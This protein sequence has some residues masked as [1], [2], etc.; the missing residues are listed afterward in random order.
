MD[1]VF[2]VSAAVGAAVQLLSVAQEVLGQDLAEGIPEVLDAVS[3]DDG[4]DRRVGVRQD[5][6]EVHDK[7]RLLQLLIKQCEAVE[8]VDGQPANSKQSHYDGEG[9]GDADLLLQQ[10]VVLA[11]PV[12]NSLELDLY[13]LVPGHGEDL[14][15][16]AEHDEQW[17][18]HTEKKVKVDHVMHVHHALKEAQEL[19]A[20][21][22]FSSSPQALHKASVCSVVS[23][24]AAVA[25]RSVL[26]VPAKE[27]DEADDEGEDP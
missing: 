6:G 10:A 13:Q 3:V 21:Y 19:A 12:A 9:F 20:M 14:Q 15:V 18:Q 2:V 25:A 26:Q 4:V 7:I 11:V 16:D 24:S 22:Q 5:D 8:D 17:R 1:L 27:R 23:T